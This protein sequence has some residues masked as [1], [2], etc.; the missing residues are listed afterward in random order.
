MGLVGFAVEIWG[1]KLW[2]RPLATRHHF[3]K[4]AMPKLPWNTCSVRPRR[5]S[6]MGTPTVSDGPSAIGWG[7]VRRFCQRTLWKQRGFS[8]SFSALPCLKRPAFCRCV[9]GKA[10]DLC[11]DGEVQSLLWRL[12]GW[13][14]PFPPPSTAGCWQDGWWC[15]WSVVDFVYWWWLSG[16]SQWFSGL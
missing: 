12:L 10:I 9:P 3:W 8:M 16:I 6:D 13:A 11:Q 14:S 2:W 1:I 15:Q 7:D 5:V 4:R